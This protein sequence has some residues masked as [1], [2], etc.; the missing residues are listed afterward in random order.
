M[1]FVWASHG[2]FGREGIVDRNVMAV[3]AHPSDV[4]CNAG[5]TL[6]HLIEDGA[7]VVL[8]LRSDDACGP[9][10]GRE[11]ASTRRE[12]TERA[13]AVLGVREVVWG[14]FPNGGVKAAEPLLRS[15]VREIRRNRID[16]VLAPDP[17][18]LWRRRNSVVRLAHADHIEA[19][20]AVLD[21]IHPRAGIPRFYPELTAEGIHPWLVHQLWLFDT[22]SPDHFVSVASTW[23]LKLA[24]L[25]C[26][27]SQIA[28]RLIEEVTAEA[29]AL[30]EHSGA[31]SE[32]FRRLCLL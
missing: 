3:A 14:D 7:R 16:L 24:A 21:A 32:G 31:R 1:R 6:G 26:H 4:A 9:G 5:G 13:A 25:S 23:E 18:A 10:A 28:V 2:G 12:E 8:F 27:A 15:L 30:R 29:E 22:E 20:R 19:G 11:A 17:T